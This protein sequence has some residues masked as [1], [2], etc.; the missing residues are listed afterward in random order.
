MQIL[1]P[2]AVPQDGRVRADKAEIIAALHNNNRTLADIGAQFGI[3][4]E[5]VRQI[6][7]AAG[8]NRSFVRARVAAA[9]FQR[10]HCD[11]P[12]VLR[13]C[14]R[15]L[16][17]VALSK[18][19]VGVNGKAVRPCMAYA[20]R[21]GGHVYWSIRRP[22]EAADYYA[23]CSDQFTLII[24]GHLAPIKQTMFSASERLPGPKGAYGKRHDYRTYLNA[25]HY[26]EEKTQ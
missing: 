18:T 20:R 22:A 3:T 2:C 12:F 26:L 6:G 4:R 10:P 23:F 15:G 25:W 16:H 24:P 8:I 14:G 9:N 17:C 7:A 5:R 1:S 11:H 19:V 21:I 13:C